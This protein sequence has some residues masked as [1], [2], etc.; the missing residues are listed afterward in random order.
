MTAFFL[1]PAAKACQKH[2][3][4]PKWLIAPNLRVANQWK[5]QICRGGVK[6]INLHSATLKSLVHDLIASAV[7]S[8][9]LKF[10]TAF[11]C[12]QIMTSVVTGCLNDG[13]LNYFSEINSVEQLA[14]LLFASIQDLRLAG[15]DSS[16]LVKESIEAAAKAHDLEVIYDS[17]VA[18]L[19]EK[20]LIDY[21]ECLALATKHLKIEN[22]GLPADLIVVLPWNLNCSR[23]ENEFLECLKTKAGYIGPPETDDAAVEFGPEFISAVGEVNEI[24]TVLRRAFHGSTNF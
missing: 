18:A 19:S 23:L 11:Q 4:H 1:L 6:T 8:K 14:N 20:K 17:Y 24:Q 7:A 9:G 15:L 12:S 2:P 21:A 3:L 16:C 10:A 13:K 5:E 22:S